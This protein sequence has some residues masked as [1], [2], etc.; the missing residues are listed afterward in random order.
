MP[1]AG[2]Q[3]RSNFV[4]T[5]A[6]PDKRTSRHVDT[7]SRTGRVPPVTIFPHV[8]PSNPPVPTGTST[9]DRYRVLFR[10]GDIRLPQRN[11]RAAKAPTTLSYLAKSYLIAARQSSCLQNSLGHATERTK[12]AS[13]ALCVKARFIILWSTTYA[14]YWKVTSVPAIPKQTIL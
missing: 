13:S 7:G 10:R 3:H 5:S 12:Y 2:T 1:K 9:E 6:Q 4:P 11:N 14:R 8:A